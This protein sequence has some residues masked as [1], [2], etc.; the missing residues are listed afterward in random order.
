[1]QQ[2]LLRTAINGHY[3][4]A[5]HRQALCGH[6]ETA[7]LANIPDAC[8]NVQQVFKCKIKIV[9]CRFSLVTDVPFVPHLQ[10][11]RLSDNGIARLGCMQV[12]TSNS[13]PHASAC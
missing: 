9:L 4:F 3:Y 13:S 2:H 6:G 8:R 10:S 1:M 12:S 11:L 5:A 7:S